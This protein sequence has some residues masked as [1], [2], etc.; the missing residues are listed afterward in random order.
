MRNEK[1]GEDL[2]VT[3]LSL[4]PSTTNLYDDNDDNGD[5]NDDDNH[6]DDDND[7]DERFT[8]I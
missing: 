1:V 3:T 8:A 6:N 2:M 4:C 5:D 7:D